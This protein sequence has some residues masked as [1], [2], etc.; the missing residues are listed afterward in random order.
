MTLAEELSQKVAA[1][2]ARVVVPTEALAHMNALWCSIQAEVWYDPASDATQRFAKHL[3]PH[4]EALN[5]IFKFK[6]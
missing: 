5:T 2:E 1:L 3:Q 4:I 6:T